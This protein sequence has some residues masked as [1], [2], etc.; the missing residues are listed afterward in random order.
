VSPRDVVA[1]CLPDPATLG[2]K[3]SG[4]TCAGV[5][6]TGTARTASPRRPTSTTSSTT[7]GRCAST[8]TSASCGRRRSTRRW[9]GAVS[10]GTWTGTG[11]LGPEAFDAVPVPRPAHGVRLRPGRC[12]TIRR[13]PTLTGSLRSVPGA[14]WFDSC[15]GPALRATRWPGQPLS[16]LGGP[17]GRRSSHSFFAPLGLRRATRPLQHLLQYANARPRRCW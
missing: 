4:K 14:Q 13:A 8:A 9:P 3:M 10:N 6:V 2:D 1:A 17:A 12:A 5:L 15:T 11:V 16:A 7:R